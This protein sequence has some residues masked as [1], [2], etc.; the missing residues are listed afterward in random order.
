MVYL[1]KFCM[2][3]IVII[4]SD[5][6]VVHIH[7][8]A[9]KNN[10]VWHF[11]FWTDNVW[12]FY[13]AYIFQQR[14]SLCKDSSGPKSTPL[15]LTPWRKGLF[16]PEACSSSVG[17]TTLCGTWET[18]PPLACGCYP[19]AVQFSPHPQTLFSNI[20]LICLLIRRTSFFGAVFAVLFIGTHPCN[21]SSETAGVKGRMANGRGDGPYKIHDKSCGNFVKSKTPSSVSISHVNH[22]S[23]MSEVARNSL[24]RRW[25]RF[26]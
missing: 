22:R 6:C 2:D 16:F 18:Q 20:I 23:Q 10:S 8:H 5:Q 14:P 13:F 24:L 3:L 4:S 17:Q 11:S 19:V 1:I 25:F 12:T 21:S 15:S 26:Q 9:W 7:F